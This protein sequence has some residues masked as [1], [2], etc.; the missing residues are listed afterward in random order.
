MARESTEVRKT[1]LRLEYLIKEYVEKRPKK[2]RDYKTYEE[3]YKIR[4]KKC[5]NELDSLVEEAVNSIKIYST[6]ERGAKRKLT[7]KQEIMLLLLQKFFQKSNRSMSLMLIVFTWLSEIDISYKTIER[8]YSDSLVQLAIH[9]LFVLLIRKKGILDVDLAGDGTGYS[10]NISQ[11][12]AT[13]AQKR[14]DKS[15]EASATQK[16]IYSFSILDL[17]TNLYVA[18]GVSMVSEKAAFLEAVKMLSE[19]NIGVNSFRLDRYFSCEVY[20][21]LIQDKFGKVTLYIVPKIN[22]A[23]LGLGIW[24]DNALRFVDDPLS[25]L[26]EYFQ[27]NQSESTIAGDK[28]RTGWRIPQKIPTRID[29]ACALIN[30]WHNLFWL[31]ADV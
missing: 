23:H 25:F 30:V 6:E 4:L 5:F 21:D 3:Q 22:F 18:F 31:G 12:Y 28:K 2:K 16:F 14:K 13:T 8:K 10:V 11:H 15:K 19:L 20:A 1:A 27:R 9:N 26:K 24:K 7:L 29:T 17:K